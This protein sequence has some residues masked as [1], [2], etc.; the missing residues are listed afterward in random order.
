MKRLALAFALALAVTGCGKKDKDKEPP[1][2]PPADAAAGKPVDAAVAGP[3]DA[4]KRFEECIAAINTHQASDTLRGCYAV[5]AVGVVVDDSP[6][7][8]GVD[9][10]L[11]ANQA[12][13]QGFPDNTLEPQVI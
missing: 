12:F 10:I 5:D 4:G 9:E 2:T 7:L 6:D 8:K 1:P 11:G 13:W 3:V